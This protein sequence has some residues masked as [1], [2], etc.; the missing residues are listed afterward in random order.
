[1]KF[2]CSKELLQ[3]H[4]EYVQD[5]IDKKDFPA[6][7]SGCEYEKSKECCKSANWV[8]VHY[9]QSLK[10]AVSSKLGLNIGAPN[11]YS[12]NGR[13]L[14]IGT[15][16]EQHAANAVLKSITPD[17]TLPFDVTYLLFSPAIR[18]KSKKVI[19]AC[20]NCNTIFS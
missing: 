19:D 10:D 8:G 20:V 15:C 1:M 2:N 17:E 3:K 9:H 6:M 12:A 11:G 16:A 4:A 5:L 7:T 18:P 14:T 13:A